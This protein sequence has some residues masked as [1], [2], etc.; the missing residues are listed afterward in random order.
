MTW[1]ALA[2]SCDI[3][4]G[5]S[6]GCLLEGRELVIWRDSG[7]AA[8]VWDDRCPH[9]GMR[10]SFGFVRGDRIACLYHG[11]Q[12][13]TA[14]QCRAIPAHPELDVPATI[15]V[16][17][18]PT[19]EVSGMI[20]TSLTEPA[21][22]PPLATEAVPVRSVTIDCPPDVVARALD[23]VTPCTEPGVWQVDA[24][25]APCLVAL[26]PIDP[27]RTAL[28]FVLLAATAEAETR[29]LVAGWAEAL[30]DAIEADPVAA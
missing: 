27:T 8:H 1:V 13:D 29:Q 28:H 16:T 25:G 5:T 3:E 21:D 26:Q 22:V 7:G 4:P 14:G 18:H 20:W 23:G 15:R 6:S 10:M 19:V 11:W 12:Y 24:A 9:R 17:T 2:L 30:R